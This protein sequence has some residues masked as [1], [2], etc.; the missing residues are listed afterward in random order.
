MIVGAH[1]N[2]LTVHAVC[3]SVIEGVTYNIN[4]MS[5]KRFVDKALCLT[6]A[7]TRA[8]RLYGKRFIAAVTSPVL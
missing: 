1:R 3:N 2:S 7:E 6:G 8:F 5:A 4:I